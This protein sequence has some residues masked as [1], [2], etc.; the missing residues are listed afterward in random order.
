MLLH[1][2]HSHVKRDLILQEISRSFGI[3]KQGLDQLW[4]NHPFGHRQNDSRKVGHVLV[5]LAKQSLSAQCSGD[6]LHGKLI[7]Q[8]FE[9]VR[10]D[11]IPPLAIR[12]DGRET[13]DV[14][15][16]QWVEGCIGPV[17][18]RVLF[19]EALNRV[20]PCFVDHF[21]AF[22]S[23]SWMSLIGVP[24]PWSCSVNMGKKRMQ[25]AFAKY[26][27]LPAA[28]RQDASKLVKGI[29]E[30]MR[31]NRIGRQDIAAFLIQLFFA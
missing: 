15:L 26:L 1:R 30:I 18:M 2:K 19:G 28:E 21:I 7:D 12:K 23:K 11:R 16:M 27:K 31:Q 20:D 29:E 17:T 13:R 6:N 8:L 14:S 5:N 10:W 25:A 24:W 4:K 3:S 9:Y 22:E